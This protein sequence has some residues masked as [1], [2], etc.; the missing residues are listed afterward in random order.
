MSALDKIL[1]ERHPGRMAKPLNTTSRD[2]IKTHAQTKG[3]EH[4]QNMALI[5][6]VFVLVYSKCFYAVKRDKHTHTH[7]K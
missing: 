6:C 1:C 5:F 4:A 2:T 7:K 3:I